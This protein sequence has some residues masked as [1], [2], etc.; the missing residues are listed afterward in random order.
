VYGFDQ[1][2]HEA[3]W[4]ASEAQRMH[5]RDGIPYRRMAVLVRSKRHILPEL[6]R[7]LERR[8]IPHDAPDTR[9]ADHPAVR[10]VLD[11]VRAATT[12]SDGEAIR[13]I[14]LGPLLRLPLSAMRD[15]QRDQSRTGDPWP[16]VIR[17]GV[18]GG[19]ELADLLEDGSWATGSSAAEGFWHLWSTLPQFAEAAVDPQRGPDRAAWSSLAQVLGRLGERDPD[20]TLTDYLRWSESEDFEATPLLEYRS[21][22]PDRLALT[23]LHQA[24]GLGWDLVIIADAREGVFPDLRTRESLLGSRHLSRSQPEDSAAYARYRLQEEMRLAYTAMCRATTR[25]VWTCTTTG[26][27]D[28][29]GVPSRFMSMVSGSDAGPLA[30]P[31][32]HGRPVTPMEAEAWLRRMVRD[33]A[34]PGPRRLAALRNLTG[35]GE[36]RKREAASFAGIAERGPDTGLIPSDLSLSPSQAESYL[37]CPRLYVFRRWLHVDSGRSVYSDL[38]SLV[39]DV[40]E[41]VETAARTRGDAHGTLDEAMEALDGLFDPGAYGGEPWATAWKRRAVRVLTHLYESWPTK[42]SVAVVE[43]PVEMTVAGMRWRGRIDRIEVE[44]RE[45][46][47]PLVRIVDYKTGTGVPTKADAARSVQLGFYVLAAAEDP[48][49]AALGDID[50]AQLWFPAVKSVSVTTRDFDTSLLP[51]VEGLMQQAAEGI[52][53]EDWTPN[54]SRQCERCSVRKVCPEWPEG[55]EAYLG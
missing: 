42:G 37:T 44:E 33:P 2:T 51:E 38:G 50:A 48:E 53:A 55:K 7:S 49:L 34:Q 25:V 20:A 13:R 4:I 40:L 11:C 43:R 8:G 46:G 54:A 17:R 28:G 9:L 26:F 14:L 3:E 31:G 27:D 12:A 35:P 10:L 6:S 32:A 41:Q 24:K 39:H 15:V 45:E 47:A 18:P 16:A 22:D 30:S 23:T 19:S 52:T 29:R 21:G 36:W 1:L 5:L